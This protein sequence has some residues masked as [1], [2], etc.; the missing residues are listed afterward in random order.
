MTDPHRV[1]V[2]IIFS[3]ADSRIDGNA[4]QVGRYVVGR[5]ARCPLQLLQHPRKSTA[6]RTTQYS[7]VS[8]LHGSS[9]RLIINLQCMVVLG[10]PPVI[11]EKG[12]GERQNVRRNK[13][14]IMG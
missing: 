10:N 12:G 5:K 14:I 9:G 3:G 1:N 13:T 11:V 6:A 7:K 2:T 8:R 4:K